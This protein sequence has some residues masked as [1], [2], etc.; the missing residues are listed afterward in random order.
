MN[1]ANK[2]H[3]R[4]WDAKIEWVDNHK[5]LKLSESDK[6][7][8]LRF[9]SLNSYI[10]KMNKSIDI[11][12]IS[13]NQLVKEIKEREKKI[14]QYEIEGKGLYQF[15]EKLKSSLEIT[16]YYTEGKTTKKSK[17]FSD[18]STTK[19]IV[20]SQ[21]LLRF[22]TKNVK[23]LHSINM[24]PK[25]KDILN[26]IKKVDSKW[27]NENGKNLTIESHTDI[28]KIRKEI[29]KYFHP[30]IEKLFKRNYQRILDGKYS[31][32]KDKLYAELGKLNK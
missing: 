4:N 9:R 30:I 17:R 20:Y 29:S 13:I 21:C 3:K 23:K 14:K 2:Q 31:L 1:I 7:K 25:R 28:K 16:T 15:L 27:Y 12:N 18:I 26:E 10:N 32:T 6:K 19:E 5:Y 22:S 11:R 24:G 8:L